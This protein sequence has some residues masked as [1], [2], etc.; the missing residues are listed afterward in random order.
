MLDKQTIDHYIIPLQPIPTL[1]KPAGQIDAEIKCVLFDIYGT[2]FISGSGDIGVTKQQL[3]RDGTINVLFQKYQVV[4]S[5][6]RVIADLYATIEQHHAVL[7]AN[8]IDYPEIEIDHVWSEILNCD[9]METIRDFA[10]EFELIVNPVYPMPNLRKTLQSIRDGKKAMGIISNAQFY[11][12]LLFSWF[13]GFEPENLGFQSE[14]ILYSY[15]H[16]YAKPSDFL[17]EQ[18]VQGL[19]EMKIRPEQTI[20]VGNDMRNDI[21]PAKKSGMKT[22]LFAGDRRSLRLRETDDCCNNLSADVIITDLAQLPGHLQ[23]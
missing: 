11:T 6:D 14:L 8:G 9:D 1:L 12:P 21:Y 13:C 2:L 19:Q 5:P 10:T 18:A 16:G 22:A 4:Q 17:F 7:R 23:V 20:Y 15:R 3:L